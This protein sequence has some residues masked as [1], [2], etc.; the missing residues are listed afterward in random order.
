M[1]AHD[2][3]DPPLVMLAADTAM[4]IAGTTPLVMLIADATHRGIGPSLM[5]TSVP[6][7]KPEPDIRPPLLLH[8][9]PV[10]HVDIYMDDFIGLAQGS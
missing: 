8:A 3:W 9:G 2:N 7:C 6:P 10:A 1:S 4:L 5:P